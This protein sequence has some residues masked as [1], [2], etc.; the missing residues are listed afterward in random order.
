MIAVW[1]A[2]TALSAAGEPETAIMTELPGVDYEGDGPLDTERSSQPP[3]AARS[4]KVIR[5]QCVFEVKVHG[6]VS[7]AAILYALAPSPEG[8]RRSP[9]LP[10]VHDRCFCAKNRAERG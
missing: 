8:S 7:L 4:L 10:F 2:R 5:K 6:F 9:P 3:T 1:G